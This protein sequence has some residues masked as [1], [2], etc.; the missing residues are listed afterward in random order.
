MEQAMVTGRMSLDKKERGSAVL[1][2]SG[3]N[4]SQAINRMYDRL[5]REGNADFLRQPDTAAERTSWESA[6]RFVDRLSEPLSGRFDGMSKAEIR[7]ERLRA[8]G[9][10]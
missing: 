9:L 1:R 7:A 2:E 10:M 8:R 6:A 4:A 5:C 3:M